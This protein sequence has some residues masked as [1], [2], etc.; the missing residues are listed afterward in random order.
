MATEKPRLSISMDEKTY[1][2]VLEYKEQNGIATQSKAI[3]RLMEIGIAKME[4]E[5][6]KGKASP[7]SEEAQELAK[8]YDRLDDH[9]KRVVRLVVDEE[10]VRCKADAKKAAFMKMAENQYDFEEEPDTQASSVKESDAV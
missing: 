5:L 8:D 2:K 6:E 7:Y 4:R 3:I 1:E 9:G 10:K